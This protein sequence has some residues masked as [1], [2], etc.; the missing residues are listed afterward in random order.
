MLNQDKTAV[1]SQY[2]N[3]G[4]KED[5]G[6]GGIGPSTRSIHENADGCQDALDTSDIDAALQRELD[7]FWLWEDRHDPDRSRAHAESYRDLLSIKWRLVA[8][9]GGAA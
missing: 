6:D 7:A 8:L 3:G 1:G 5:D 4:Y 2:P 9:A